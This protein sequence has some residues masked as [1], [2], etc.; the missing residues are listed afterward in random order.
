M[1]FQDNPVFCSCLSNSILKILS[2]S[3]RGLCCMSAMIS[4]LHCLKE[5][6]HTH[7]TLKDNSVFQ[8]IKKIKLYQAMITPTYR[9]Q[10]L[11][12]LNAAMSPALI[13][14]ME[15][16]HWS[17]YYKAPLSQAGVT[18]GW[19]LG[20]WT[21]CELPNTRWTMRWKRKPP[22]NGVSQF[23]HFI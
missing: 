2:L 21:P 6:R 13:Q 7:K 22:N 11:G 12:V 19:V 20:Y 17:S 18:L 8:V 9:Q 3:W 4:T 5:H 14:W 23:L 16:G 1:G 15:Q 10:N